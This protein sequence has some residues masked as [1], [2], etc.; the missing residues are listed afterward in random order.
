MVTSFVRQEI[1]ARAMLHVMPVILD[2]LPVLQASEGPGER[3]E[4]LFA[5]IEMCCKSLPVGI[6]ST[7]HCVPGGCTTN[8][9]NNGGNRGMKLL[10]DSNTNP[11]LMP[12]NKPLER[13]DPKSRMSSSIEK[14]IKVAVCLS[15]CLTGQ[16]ACSACPSGTYTD[17]SGNA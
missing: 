9:S 10:Q 3:G 5:V 12:V 7:V 8:A 11:S 1:P 6:E 17:A 2:I 4:K 14:S 16:T 13:T 15:V